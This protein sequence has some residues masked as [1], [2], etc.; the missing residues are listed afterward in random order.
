MRKRSLTIVEVNLLIVAMLVSRL[1]ARALCLVWGSLES[2]L[3]RLGVLQVRRNPRH[4]MEGP[5]EHPSD[6]RRFSWK[7]SH[8]TGHY[9]WKIEPFVN[10]RG[11]LVVI[12]HGSKP[13]FS[14]LRVLILTL[15]SPLFLGI[16]CLE[17]PVWMVSSLWFTTIPH[18]SL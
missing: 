2:G 9:Y 3:W 5:L 17:P 1:L 4:V 10:Q 12:H 6:T 8:D 16:H 15:G 18:T 14:L 11:H 13:H 7:S